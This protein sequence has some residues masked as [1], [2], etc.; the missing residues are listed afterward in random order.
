M[1]ASGHRV[2]I[3]GGIRVEEHS[4]LRSE[5]GI[6]EGSGT[7]VSE[8]QYFDP[9]A[10]R[11]VPART[12]LVV[13]RRPE[14]LP[15]PG[16]LVRDARHRHLAH[17]ARDRAD[18]AAQRR[19]PRRAACPIVW[20]RHGTRGVEDGG[21]FMAA[22]PVPARRRPPH[23]HVGLR[24]PRRARAPRPRTG[25]SR[26]PGSRRSSRPTS[27]SSCARLGAETVL[28]TGVLTNQCVGGD[29]QGRDLPRLQ[30]DRRRGVRRARRLPHLH[31]PAIE[32]IRVGWGAG[33]HARAD[34]RRARRVPGRSGDA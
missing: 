1:G 16:R 14:R 31:E 8:T 2:E 33:E 30:A 23:G 29:L 32:M 19:V 17:A 3:S 7:P 18:A 10:W 11:L 22:A 13:D 4:Y 27:S 24:D 26:R 12:V 5:G 25:S 28:I 6:K 34:A 9:S 15:A 20:T 21:P